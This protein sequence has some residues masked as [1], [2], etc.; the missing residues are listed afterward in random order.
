[1]K[2]LINTSNI[3]IGGGIQVSLSFIEALKKYTNNFYYILLSPKVYGQINRNKYPNNFKFFLI[4]NSPSNLKKRIKIL[5]KLYRLENLISP[6]IV[7]TVFGPAYWKPKSL[8]VSGF[9][10]GWCYTPDS[11]AFVRLSLLK[12]LKLKFVILIKNKFIK[13]SDYL[14]VETEVAKRNIEKHLRYSS[15][16]IFVVGNTYHQSFIKEPIKIKKCTNDIYKIL[17]LSANYPHKNLN[18]INE[19]IKKLNLKS[20]FKFQFILTIPNKQF[21]ENFFDSDSIINIGPQDI[22]ACRDLYLQADVLFLPT[23]LETFTANYPEAMITRTPILTSD[24]N[25]ARELCGD[26]ALYFNPL[27]SIDI[28][29]KILQL[30]TDKNLKNILIEN[31]IMR[32]KKFETSDS[33]ANKYLS[34]FKK[35]VNK[36]I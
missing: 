22:E 28:A 19:V 16:K 1:M 10:D 21:R 13:K 17:V 33:R 2:I 31:G 36:E 32:L 6:D 4:E 9:A 25:F 7:F 24:L 5:N 3:V 18:I 8:H 23:L 26:A 12:R 29:D 14:I 20:N 30:R 15:E 35:I 27:S 34:I 11:I